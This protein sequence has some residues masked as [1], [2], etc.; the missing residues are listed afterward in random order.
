MRPVGAIVFGALA[1][2]FGRRPTLMVNVVSY[3]VFVMASALAP[4]FGWFLATRALFGVAMGG[5]WGVGAAL[6]LESL[7]AEG[8][9]FS[10][11]LQEGYVVGSMLAALLYLIFPYLHGTGTLSGV[12]SVVPDWCGAFAV[13]AAA[14]AERGG[15]AGVAGAAY[16]DEGKGWRRRD[17]A[18][19]GGAEVSAQFAGAD[20]LDDGVYGVQP[21]RR[22]IVS[23]V[24]E[25]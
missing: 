18:S 9:G 11:L 4:T 21:W 13:V 2:K 19:G 24:S 10:G 15:I 22:R 14:V 6:A 5:E 16:G 7:P 25:A 1:E 3:S 23:N 12:A 20:G 17:V 8:R